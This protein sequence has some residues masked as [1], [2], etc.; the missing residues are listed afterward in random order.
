MQRVQPQNMYEASGER[1]R[2]AAAELLSH[3]SSP[4]AVLSRA[5]SRAEFQLARCI[6]ERSS[7]TKECDQ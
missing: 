1:I 2:A 4:A 5:S 3:Q 6:I 7:N